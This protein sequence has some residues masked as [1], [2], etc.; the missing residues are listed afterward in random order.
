MLLARTTFSFLLLLTPIFIS[1]QQTDSIPAK[2]DYGKNIISF[3]YGDMAFSRLTFGYERFL[4][5]DRF[6]SIYVP[7]SIGASQ[8][9][10]N[11]NFYDPRY[12]SYNNSLRVEYRTGFDVKIYPLPYGKIQYYLG[13]SLR[14]SYYQQRY[15]YTASSNGVFSATYSVYDESNRFEFMVINGFVYQPSKRFSVG[16]D[17]GVGARRDW[18]PGRSLSSSDIT[19]NFNAWFGYRF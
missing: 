4:S 8:R 2:K 19:A 13:P 15:D 18:A 3:S 5:K 11:F 1:A 16:L 14:Y 12:P 17:A 6:V 7:L 9:Y 10:R